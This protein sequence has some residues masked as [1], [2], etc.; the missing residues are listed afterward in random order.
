[1]SFGDLNA[2]AADDTP[3]LGHR[4]SRLYRLAY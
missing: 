4:Q 3:G 1:L 2:H